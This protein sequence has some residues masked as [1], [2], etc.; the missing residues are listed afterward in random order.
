MTHFSQKL[1]SQRVRYIGTRMIV[2]QI[3]QK[4]GK[5]WSSKV[6]QHFDKLSKTC[7]SIKFRF[8]LYR[9]QNVKNYSYLIKRIRDTN[10][11]SAAF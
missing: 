4:G 3:D 8:I 7:K 2:V 5:N 11:F 9:K 6:F 10:A 1:A